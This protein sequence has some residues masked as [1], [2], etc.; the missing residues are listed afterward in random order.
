MRQCRVTDETTGLLDTSVVLQPIRDVFSCDS[1][2]TRGGF[3]VNRWRLDDVLVLSDAARESNGISVERIYYGTILFDHTYDVRLTGSYMGSKKVWDY[4]LDTM[5]SDLDYYLGRV[6]DV[7]EYMADEGLIEYENGQVT[8]LPR[9]GDYLFAAKENYIG[10]ENLYHRIQYRD[11]DEIRTHL[12]CS[13]DDDWNV[14]CDR[15][16]EPF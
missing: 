9:A 15:I 11:C 5:Q 1:T 6:A 13:L 7:C 8:H 3:D 12:R 16:P 2:K 14:L 4:D 10:H